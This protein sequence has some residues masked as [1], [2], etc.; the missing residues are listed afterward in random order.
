MADGGRRAQHAVRHMGREASAARP[1]QRSGASDGA[2]GTSGG[3]KPRDP[4]QDR[5]GQLSSVIKANKT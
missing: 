5:E 3:K 1:C 4:E 2:A